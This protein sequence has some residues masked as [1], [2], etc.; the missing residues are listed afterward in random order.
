MTEASPPT[1]RPRAL[2]AVGAFLAG[3]RELD[4]ADRTSVLQGLYPDREQLPAVV[5]RLLVLAVLSSIIA[6]LGLLLDSPAAVI[7]AMLLGPFMTP[8]LGISMAVLHGWPARL[9]QS[10]VLT[11]LGVAVS[12]LTAWVVGLTIAAPASLNG[13]SDQLLALTRPGLLDLGVALAA[14]VAAGYATVRRSGAEALPGV[15]VSVTLE[16]PLAAFGILVAL[17][18]TG[19]AGEAA[20]NFVT[21]LGAIVVAAGVT[22]AAL[23]FA[24][25]DSETDR[26]RATTGMIVSATVVA[27]IAV[28]LTLRT[29]RVVADEQLAE[30][31]GRTVREWDP[32]VR[33]V[34]L[35]ADEHDGVATVVLTLTGPRDPEPAWRLADLLA[36]R[37]GQTVEVDIRFTRAEE[38]RSVA[39]D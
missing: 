13:L 23:G 21:N 11:A 24:R 7:G 16:P 15:A 30:E 26:R 6:A 36:Q 4:A 19:A 38:F 9:A 32:S 22:M 35:E 34:E 39:T 20:L 18:E 10:I 31:V 14:G 8:L 37:R 2:S 25:P 3:R 5:S 29:L 28:P 33:V 27:L 17:G 12:C 1:A